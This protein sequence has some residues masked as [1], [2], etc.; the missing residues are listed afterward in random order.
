MYISGIFH[1]NVENSVELD[2]RAKVLLLFSIVFRA[3]YFCNTG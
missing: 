1:S 3:T 2:Y